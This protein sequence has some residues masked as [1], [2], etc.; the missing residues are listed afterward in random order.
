[1]SSSSTSERLI[2]A[3]KLLGQGLISQ[4]DFDAKKKEIMAVL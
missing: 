3:K 4:S 2:E 1:M